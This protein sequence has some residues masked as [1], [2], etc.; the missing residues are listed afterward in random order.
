MDYNRRNKICHVYSANLKGDALLEGPYKTALTKRIEKRWGPLVMV[1]RLD[2]NVRQGIPDILVLFDS[3]FWAALEG[4]RNA[5]APCQPNQPY[6]VDLMDRLCFAAFIYPENEEGVLNE[7]E[8]AYQ[9]YRQTRH[10]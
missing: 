6:Y 2:A 9:S 8:Q 10:A 5:K 1:V 7:L 3:G 4:K